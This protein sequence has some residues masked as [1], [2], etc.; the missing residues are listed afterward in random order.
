MFPGGEY[1]HARNMSVLRYGLAKGKAR[2]KTATNGNQL[3]QCW[4]LKFSII[5][6]VRHIQVYLKVK[7]N[8]SSLPLDRATADMIRVDEEPP[9]QA[10]LKIIEELSKHVFTIPERKSSEQKPKPPWNLDNLD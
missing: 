4:K 9:S 10:V 1:H 5:P 3:R 2:Q 8:T 6:N 7:T